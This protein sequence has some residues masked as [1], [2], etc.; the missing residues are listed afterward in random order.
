MYGHLQMWNYG[1]S[2]QGEKEKVRTKDAFIFEKEE[3]GQ[4][5]RKRKGLKKEENFKEK[6]K[7]KRKI[8]LF[9]KKEQRREINFTNCF[10]S[11]SII[12]ANFFSLLAKYLFFLTKTF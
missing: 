9:K 10:F 1:L 4:E 11:L 2:P 8:W 6:T 3:K 12:T 7:K 5:K